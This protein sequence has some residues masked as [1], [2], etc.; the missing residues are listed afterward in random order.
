MR[1]ETSPR[2]GL[3]GN[4]GAA[5]A[6][7]IGALG[8]SVLAS[9]CYNPDLTPGRFLCGPN[10]ECPDNQVCRAGRCVQDGEPVD[11]AHGVELVGVVTGIDGIDRGV[12]RR[13]AIPS[14]VREHG[15][16]V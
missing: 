14:T 6:L 15:R 7:A 9:G 8:T 1:R 16:R 12:E 10:G 11:A 2:A 13:H 3:S 4:R 5:A